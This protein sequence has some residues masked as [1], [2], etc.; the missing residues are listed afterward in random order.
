MLR[1]QTWPA[2][3]AHCLN[4][5]Q[6]LA[7]TRNERKNGKYSD[8]FMVKTVLA[9]Q[10]LLRHS[11]EGHHTPSLIQ[12]CTKQNFRQKALGHKHRR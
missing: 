3:I 5:V 7:G 10:I 11:T 8:D 1:C 12:Q 9:T 4:D 2:N 6:T